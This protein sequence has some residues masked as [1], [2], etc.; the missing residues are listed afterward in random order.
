MGITVTD[1]STLHINGVEIDHE[2][3]RLEMAPNGGAIIHVKS[4][5][6]PE[7]DWKQLQGSKAKIAATHTKKVVTEGSRGVSSI[8]NRAFS[9]K[10]ASVS[11]Y[12]R[13]TLDHMDTIGGVTLRVNP[14]WVV[15]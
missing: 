13:H 14:S 6:L 2:G 5:T 7:E 12:S 8:A 11:Y 9:G 15:E 10:L 4:M 3:L 1:K